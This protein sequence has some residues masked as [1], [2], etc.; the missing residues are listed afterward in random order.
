MGAAKKQSLDRYALF[1]SLLECCFIIIDSI[2]AERIHLSEGY[3]DR[4]DAG[5]CEPTLESRVT[6]TFE[7]AKYESHNGRA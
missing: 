4:R 6:L 5:E 2:Q 1:P 7:I 3:W